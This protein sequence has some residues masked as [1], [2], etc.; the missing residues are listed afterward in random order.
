MPWGFWSDETATYWMAV[1]GW[2]ESIPRTAG[3]AGQSILYSVIESFFLT[4][5][6]WA[7]ALMRI[8]SL[9]AMAVA[10]WQ[11]KRIAEILVSVEA[12][13]IALVVFVCAP[14]AA[15]FGTSARPYALALAASLSSFRYLLEWREGA[16]SATI[17]K[18][19]ATSILTLYFHYL[20]GF[21]FVIQGLYLGYCLARGERLRW[22]LPIA[23]VI[24]L[25][26][27]LL[28][29]VSVLRS[30]ASSSWFQAAKPEFANLLWISLPPVFLLGVA[31][32]MVFLWASSRSAKWRN[33]PV[34]GEF[35]FLAA[36]WLLLAP[37]VFFA[38]SYFTPN[39]VFSARYLLFIL[40]A[41]VLLVAW[42]ISSFEHAE[43]RRL[44]TISIFAAGTLHPGLLLQNWRPS[45]QSWREPL[46]WIASQKETPEIFMTSAL[47]NAEY[48]D[49]QS[50][51]P[52]ESAN[53]APLMA[54]PILNA[55]R[56][57][58]WAFGKDA[59]AY[60]QASDLH[61]SRYLL[62][63]A[64]DSPLVSW[65][66]DYMTQAGFRS[67]RHDFNDYVVID[68]RSSQSMPHAKLK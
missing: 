51:D 26:L 58:P 36:I 29:F 7:E 49:W 45:M 44:L 4:N 56:P 37:L 34:R 11:L 64:G 47:A 48:T 19:V 33:I 2:R 32:G 46:A 57:L 68:F 16:R 43:S 5:G 20:F 28:P 39:V 62:L 67:E 13:W 1:K 41:P 38:V 14:D 9:V 59:Q 23:G 53:F 10:A 35:V 66:T 24:A 27:S 60:I 22:D 25:P 54:Y 65:M 30:T 52:H 6:P 63:A 17:A 40:P 18:Y 3:L 50:E 8:P 12:G 61:K 21:V 15:N 31:L 42:A 55:A